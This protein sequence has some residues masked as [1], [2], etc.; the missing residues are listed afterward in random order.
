MRLVDVN[1]MVYATNKT[2]PFHERAYDWLYKR[3]NEDERL[4]LPWESVMG[5]VRVA[6]NPKISSRCMTVRQAWQTVQS[7][8]DLPNV[9]V[10]GPTLR[11]RVIFQRLLDKVPVTH[12]L[13]ADAHLA[14]I[15]MGHNLA[16]ASAD[17]DFARFPGL[18][19]EN[20]LED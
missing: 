13:V 15:A 17:A 4:G 2:S 3:L 9:W 18:R 16:L 19:Y 14:A 8:L 5:F 11:H 6:S 1:L 7:W 10:P 20:P 12:K